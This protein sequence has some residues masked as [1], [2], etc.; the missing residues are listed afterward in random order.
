MTTTQTKKVNGGKKEEE[1]EIP[2]MRKKNPIME[3]KG[4]NPPR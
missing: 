3:N 1:G 4:Q 2:P